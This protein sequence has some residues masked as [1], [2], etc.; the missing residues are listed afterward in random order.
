MSCLVYNTLHTWTNVFT[1][2]ID[3]VILYGPYNYI[4]MHF[5]CGKWLQYQ[6]ISSLPRL[7]RGLEHVVGHNLTMQ[8]KVEI[9]YYPKMWLLYCT[10]NFFFPPYDYYAHESA[11]KMQFHAQKCPQNVIPRAKVPFSLKQHRALFQSWAEHCITRYKNYIF[12]I[13]CRIF[14]M[15]MGIAHF[16]MDLF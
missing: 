11:L 2:C 12:F 1:E 5:N 14:G 3:H 4:C 16:D 7:C 6:Y 9:L 13:Q 15:N 10:N 8:I